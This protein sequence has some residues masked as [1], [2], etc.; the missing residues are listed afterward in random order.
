MKI[1]V[2]NSILS[3]TALIGTEFTWSESSSRY[4]NRQRF[5]EVTMEVLRNDTQM[6]MA[7]PVCTCLG[8][9]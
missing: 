8:M 9:V 5:I 1:L 2:R 3:R 6:Y 7:V 4:R